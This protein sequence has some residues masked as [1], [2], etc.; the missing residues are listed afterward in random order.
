MGQLNYDALTPIRVG[1]TLVGWVGSKMP[2]VGSAYDA[3][4]TVIM[5]DNEL[6]V[7]VHDLQWAYMD[8]PNSIPGILE[9]VM[10]MMFYGKRFVLSIPVGSIDVFP[11]GE[12][13]YTVR[14]GESLMAALHNFCAALAND[15]QADLHTKTPAGV[16]HKWSELAFHNY[17]NQLL[18][19]MTWRGKIL[20]DLVQGTAMQARVVRRG[21]NLPVPYLDFMSAPKLFV[22]LVDWQ[23]RGR[24]NSARVIPENVILVR[25]NSAEEYE[26]GKSLFET[27]NLLE[28][29]LILTKPAVQDASFFLCLEGDPLEDW[30][31]GERVRMDEFSE[32]VSKL[33]VSTGGVE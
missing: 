29:Y 24:F 27:P 33:A 10:Q 22:S 4:V 11:S 17:P 15:I 1:P 32:I 20:N 21:F 7:N 13:D 2:K 23:V 12:I 31:D 8:S 5:G 6:P 30:I 18:Q 25:A 14:S 16:V 26:Q 9:K 28:Q 3:S 19:D